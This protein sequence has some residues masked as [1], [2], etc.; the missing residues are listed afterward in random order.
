MIRITAPF[1]F[2]AAG[3]PLLEII[4]RGRTHPSMALAGGMSL[5]AMRRIS[6]LRLNRPAQALLCGLSVTGIEAVCGLIWNRR[7]QVWDYRRMPLNWRGQ[8][9]LPYTLLW[10]LLSAAMLPLL[11]GRKK[12]RP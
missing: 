7:H 11:N 5:C 6:H 1:L 3:Y 10:T 2:G 9:C 4:W 8:I 12:R